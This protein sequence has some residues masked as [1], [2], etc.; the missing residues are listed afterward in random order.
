MRKLIEVYAL[1][2]A[3]VIVFGCSTKEEFKVQT[4][5][6]IT[7]N[8][9]D[10]IVLINPDRYDSFSQLVNRIEQIACNDS[11][12]TISVKNKYTEK[13]IGLA[14]PCWEGVRCILIARR[15]VLKRLSRIL[16]F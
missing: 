9:T 10:E 15:N 2:I 16:C 11:I 12:P 3:A 1:I 14:N 6:I 8:N 7:E 5:G 4:F 13:R